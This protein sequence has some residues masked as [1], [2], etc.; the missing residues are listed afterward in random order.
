MRWE[1][2]LWQMVQ[3]DPLNAL[4]LT[5]KTNSMCLNSTCRHKLFRQTQ[6]LFL[7]WP[8]S[9]NPIPLNLSV[10]LR[11]KFYLSH[12]L[13]F[14]YYPSYSLNSFYQVNT[15]FITIAIFTPWNN[16]PT[17]LKMFPFFFICN[18]SPL[19]ASTL[20]E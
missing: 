13:D 19:C 14:Q 10:F 4:I 6:V 3:G 8:I 18:L 15:H 9:T 7:S 16:I 5:F 2:V 11:E 1:T 20:V 12:F 17:P